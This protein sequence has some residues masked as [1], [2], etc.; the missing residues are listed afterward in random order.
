MIHHVGIASVEEEIEKL[1]QLGLEFIAHEKLK[2]DTA[3]G[4]L[5]LVSASQKQQLLATIS[6]P[7]KRGRKPLTKLVNIS[8]DET[9]KSKILLRSGAS[10]KVCMT[11][12][13][14]SLVSWAMTLFC[15]AKRTRRYLETLYSCVWST[16][17]AHLKHSVC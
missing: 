3:S 5:S 7:K 13:D 2:R 9:V 15:Q 8:D 17:V 10:L 4:Q 16:R 1:K 12:A 11:L 6:N 14:M